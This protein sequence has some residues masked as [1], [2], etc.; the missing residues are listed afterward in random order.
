MGKR[1][2]PSTRGQMTRQS[3]RD[4]LHKLRSNDSYGVQDE[5]H[6]LQSLSIFSNYFH[7]LLSYLSLILGIFH[8]DGK[9]SSSKTSP[10]RTSIGHT[11]LASMVV[12]FS[13]VASRDS[14]WQLKAVRPTLDHLAWQLGL[15]ALFSSPSHRADGGKHLLVLEEWLS[16]AEGLLPEALP[17]NVQGGL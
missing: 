11:L 16:E 6:A 14:L 17:R 12:E 13:P 2:I 5:G 10:L 1:I 9:P 4:S 3:L 15:V 8:N 7:L